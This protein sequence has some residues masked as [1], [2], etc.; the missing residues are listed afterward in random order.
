[1]DLSLCILIDFN[2]CL[3][4][5]SFLLFYIFY[6]EDSNFLNFTVP[7][8]AAKSSAVVAEHTIKP[9]A[10]VVARQIGLQVGNG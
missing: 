7:T 3:G 9:Q 1:M 6:T 10:M 2:Q 4:K 5:R 8:L